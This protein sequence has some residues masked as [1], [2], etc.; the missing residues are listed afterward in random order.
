M[1]E[2]TIFKIISEVK[3]QEFRPSN[4]V[5][6]AMDWHVCVCVHIP[7]HLSFINIPDLER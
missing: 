6:A 4:K 7:T 3:I 5:S 1:S 2:E